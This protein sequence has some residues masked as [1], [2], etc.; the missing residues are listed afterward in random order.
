VE[1]ARTLCY[2][3][4]V[5]GFTAAVLAP[6]LLYSNSVTAHHVFM[7]LAFITHLYFVWAMIGFE[8]AELIA[9]ASVAIGR[10]QVPGIPI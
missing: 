9:L 5:K 3:E 10:V 6:Y 1:V 2:Y 7:A 4:G 8:A